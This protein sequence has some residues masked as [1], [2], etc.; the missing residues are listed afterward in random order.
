MREFFSH[1][2][3]IHSVWCLPS[4]I[5][6]RLGGTGM[7]RNLLDRCIPSVSC[8]CCLYILK[9]LPFMTWALSLSD[10]VA[11]IV[12]RHICLYRLRLFNHFP[13]YI[14]QIGAFHRHRITCP[15]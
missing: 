15:E 9:G 11:E 12:G 10:L 2:T 7:R 1:F 14:H 6:P 5:A 3:S 4:D 8:H 13:I